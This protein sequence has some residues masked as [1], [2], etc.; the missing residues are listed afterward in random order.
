M[1]YSL[2]QRMGWWHGPCASLVAKILTHPESEE[3]ENEA[4]GNL[5][6]GQS[7]THLLEISIHCACGSLV[8]GFTCFP[9]LVDA[10]ALAYM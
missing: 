8:I 10:I 5:K 6:H 1:P 3:R 2:T 4:P 7:N 9:M